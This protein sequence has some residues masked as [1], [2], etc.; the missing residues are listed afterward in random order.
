[1]DKILVVDDNRASR[2]LIRAI[3]K[4]VRCEIIEAQNGQEAIDRIQ[5]EQFNLLLLD[6]DMPVLDGLSTVR[7]IRQDP[8]F[9]DLPVV[10]VTSFAMEG[11]R[12][13]GLAAGFTAYITKPVR[14]AALRQQVQQLLGHTAG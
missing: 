8:A 1:M 12:E 4:T 11:D 3:L 13:K 2:D 9:A 5:Q 14:A 7:K 6:I 10:A